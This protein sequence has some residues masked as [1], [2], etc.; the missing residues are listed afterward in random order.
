M[1]GDYDGVCSAD[2]ILWVSVT[3][4]LLIAVCFFFSLAET[5]VVNANEGKLKLLAADGNKRAKCVLHLKEK[6]TLF[7]ATVQ[8]GLTI[9]TLIV[10]V[11]SVKHFSALLDSPAQTLG[12]PSGYGRTAADIVMVMLCAFFV[13]VFGHL[14]PK[15][16]ALL[17]PEKT[18]LT[19][20]LPIRVFG[21]ILRPVVL[22]FTGFTSLIMRI[23]GKNPDK[24][25]NPVTEEELRML[26]DECEE[27]GEIENSTKSIIDNVFDFDDLTVGEIIT[28]RKDLV[29]V[30]DD[31]TIKELVRVATESGYSRIP[32]Y[33]DDID[34]ITGFIYVKDLLRYVDNTVKSESVID[35]SMIRDAVFV[36]KT[37]TCIQM[38]DYMTKNHT[39]IAV[40]V[41]EYGG[42]NGIITMEDLVEA[43]LGSIQDEYDQEDE[44]IERV[45]EN[46]FT[47]DGATSL[48]EIG[49]IVGRD[50][51]SE[52]SDT[53]AG[54]ML[55]RMG[56]IPKD[57]EHPSVVID[58][59]RFTVQ[60]V[61]ERRI[62]K[63]L[64]VTHREK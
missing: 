39:Q 54:L 3:I 38:F 27:N 5:S 8:S 56:H 24:K 19:V 1:N 22:V 17:N 40:V 35:K 44:A 6:L 30:A 37:K 49:E 7:L 11:L 13:I 64:V 21:W 62:E 47:V 16:L 57:G 29:A 26:V 18:A 23:L 48:D 10:V 55:E 32:V 31:T 61:H 53:I 9:S 60:K 59:T 63:V 46:S 15:R 50:F 14:L 25:G 45:G 42:T 34:N 36:P 43:V 41:D 12:I 33:H 52:T 28:H 51:N 20:S 4:V 2:G 58:G